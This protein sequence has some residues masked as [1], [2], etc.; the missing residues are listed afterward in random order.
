MVWDGVYFL[1][2]FLVRILGYIYISYL[3]QTAKICK[4]ISQ[5]NRTKTAPSIYPKKRIRSHKISIKISVYKLSQQ[6]HSDPQDKNKKLNLIRLQ[7]VLKNWLYQED[8]FCLLELNTRLD[9][10]PVGAFEQR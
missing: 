10:F 3:D 2:N 5:Q 8:T 9:N 4:P 1:Y 6:L 7:I